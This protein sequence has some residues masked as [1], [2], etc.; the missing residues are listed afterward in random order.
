MVPKTL[1]K[2]ALAATSAL[3][4]G[5]ASAVA[6]VTAQDAEALK[7]TL[8][9]LGG[10]RAGNKDGTIPAWDGGYSKVPPGY[11]SGQPRPDPFADEKPLF[12]ITAAN[13]AQYRDHLS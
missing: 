12:S 7:T 2:I 9:P 4:L 3:A 11:K 10:E 13:V 1:L 8:M 6:G 5:A